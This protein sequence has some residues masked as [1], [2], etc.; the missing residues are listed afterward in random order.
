MGE[1]VAGDHYREPGHVAE[2]RQAKP[3]GLA[4]VTKDNLLLFAANEVPRTD[5]PLQD[6]RHTPSVSS[7]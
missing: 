4:H 5:A 1:R 7:E 6:V 2:I 3:A